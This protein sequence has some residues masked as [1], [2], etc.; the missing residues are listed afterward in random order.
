MSTENREKNNILAAIDENQSEA[1]RRKKIDIFTELARQLWHTDPQRGSD[2]AQTAYKLAVKDPPYTKGIAESLYGLGISNIQF[3]NY[4]QALSQLFEAL[5]IYETLGI[6]KEQGD[7]LFAIG[8]L[9]ASQSQSEQAISHLHQALTIAQETMSK[10]EMARCHHSLAQVY[11]GQG[12][13]ER[14]FNHHEQFHTLEQAIF[15][16]GTDTRV[17]DLQILHHTETAGKEAEI[18]RLKNVELEKEIAERKRVEEALQ[19]SEERF[20]TLVE[21]SVAGILVHRDT[22]PLFVNQSYAYILGYE[23]TAEILAMDSVLP[24]IAPYEQERMLSYQAARVKGEPTLAQYEYDAVRKDGSIATIQLVATMLT[25]NGEPATLA[26]II[27]I[28]ESKQAEKE[29]RD[30]EEN[31]SKAQKIAHLGFWVWD[32]LADKI[33]WSD[34]MYRIY[35]LESKVQPSNESV[36]EL[37]HPDDKEIFNLT[38]ADLATGQG[39]SSIEY[40]IVRADGQVRIVHIIAE[41]FYDESGNLLQ[42][43][44]TVQDVTERRQV[45]KA[46]QSA[47]EQLAQR[48][49]ELSTLNQL[50]QKLSFVTNLKANLKTLTV[51]MVQLFQAR[52]SIATLLNPAGTELVIVSHHNKD[53]DGSPTDMIGITIPLS[54][55]QAE[56]QV[57]ETGRSVLITPDNLGLLDKAGQKRLEKP[58]THC[59]MISPLL[60]RGKAIGTLTISADKVGRIFTLAEMGLA[61]TV[62]VQVAGAIDTARLFDELR[63]AKEAA[64]AANR[65]KSAFLSSMSHELRTPLNGILGYTQIFKHDA[66]MSA[67]QQEGVDIIH[68]SGEHLLTMINDILDLSKIEADHLDLMPVEIHFPRFLQLIV[69][70]IRPRAERKGLTFTHKSDPKLPSML[71]ADETRLR[72][73]LLNLLSN[74]VKFTQ[75]GCVTMRVRESGGSGVWRPNVAWRKGDAVLLRFEVKDTG[76]GIPVEWQAEIFEPFRQ[77]ENRQIQQTGTGLGLSISQRLVQ[78]MGGELFVQS[79]G[80]G[81][82]FWFEISL[83]LVAESSKSEKVETRT[84]TG[85]RRTTGEASFNILLVDDVVEN[86]TVLQ[87]LLT[88]LGFTVGEA[89]DGL[90]AIAQVANFK[91]DL[92]LMD[93]LMPHMD[94]LEATRQIRQLAEGQEVPIIALSASVSPEKQELSFTVGCDDFLPKPFI[95]TA[96][97]DKLQRYLPLQWIYRDESPQEIKNLIS[98]PQATLTKLLH[99]ANIGDVLGIEAQLITLKKENVQ[100]VPFVAQIKQLATEFKVDEIEQ[101]IQDYLEKK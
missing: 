86:R 71:L 76:I 34:E 36:Y 73:I 59:L 25:W 31:L 63:D 46:L 62:A 58:N 50:S 47:N 83:P 89:V 12:D 19:Q 92:I 35:G 70:M 40:R 75:Q 97:L 67:A 20:R 24:L 11:K 8:N 15:N 90:E 64:E 51:T 85:Y 80:S 66:T 14:A 41:I 52:T 56:R 68:H 29:L 81:S 101:Y 65:A 79:D 99:L 60:A 13:F 16:E 43:M 5:S 54:D 26:S 28:T 7:A 55:S 88:P 45:E 21:S 38:M 6:L 100:Y 93:L 3:A 61:E 94:G 57:I 4:E 33:S 22:N 84:I 2:L 42:M 37:I 87:A 53:K 9:Y 82:H 18:Y 98:P 1:A 95:E 91:P 39:P 17:G 77:V 72:Q 27:D 48:I 69:D 78:M 44:G 74:A 23:S 30:S 10:A 49:E 32:V 96:V